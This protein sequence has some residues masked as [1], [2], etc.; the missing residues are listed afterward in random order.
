MLTK[1]PRTTVIPGSPEVPHRAE[2]TVCVTIRPPGVPTPLPSGHW[3]THCEPVCVIVG[4]GPGEGIGVGGTVNDD[5]PIYECGQPVCRS[6]WV[7]S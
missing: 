5:Q 1:L 2:E 4:Y 3:E 7:P 6:V